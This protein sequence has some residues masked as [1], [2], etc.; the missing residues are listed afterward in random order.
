[1]LGDEGDGFKI[2]MATLDRDRIVMGSIG[3]GIARA[4][5]EASKRYASERKQFEQ[6][7]ANFQAVQFM[8]ADMAMR[9][10]AARSP[11]KPLISPIEASA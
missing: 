6:P 4:C 1:M 2:A 7:I 8:I 11:I 9:A 3:V 10:E 5:V